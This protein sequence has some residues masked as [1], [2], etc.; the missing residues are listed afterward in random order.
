VRDYYLDESNGYRRLSERNLRSLPRKQTRPLRGPGSRASTAQTSC[1]EKSWSTFDTFGRFLEVR[2]R[3]KDGSYRRHQASST[4]PGGDLGAWGSY[5]RRQGSNQKRDGRPPKKKPVARYMM[6]NLRHK[7]GPLSPSPRV[8]GLMLFGWPDRMLGKITAIMGNRAA[9]T[10]RLSTTFTGR[11]GLDSARRLSRKSPYAVFHGDA[12]RCRLSL[13]QSPEFERKI[14]LVERAEQWSLQHHLGGRGSC[15]CIS[16]RPSAR[17]IP[18]N[19]LSLGRVQADG[20]KDLD[21]DDVAP[22]RGQ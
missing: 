22:C 15:C 17:N 6:T 7:L 19:P 5:G 1:S 14:L 3:H 21:S 11:S 9:R 13:H 18:P 4:R 2:Q 8:V 16:T 12:Q 20:K 10:G